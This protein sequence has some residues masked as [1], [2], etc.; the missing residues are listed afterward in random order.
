MEIADNFLI[1]IKLASDLHKLHSLKQ[2]SWHSCKHSI[3]D[4]AQDKQDVGYT[5][6]LYIKFNFY[7]QYPFQIS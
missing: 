6:C 7:T 2:G 1:G 4:M 3:C 5:L